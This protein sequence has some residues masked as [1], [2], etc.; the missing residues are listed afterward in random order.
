RTQYGLDD[1]SAGETAP[2]LA[3]F[4]IEP[5]RAAVL[6]V[7]KRALAI[8]PALRVMASPWSAPAWMKTTGSLIKGTLRPEAYPAFAEYLRRYIQGYEAEGVPIFA[9]TVQNEPHFE[10]ENYPG[11]R[12]TPAQRAELLAHPI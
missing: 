9:I 11:M 8:N 6:P 1:D 4:S 2:T 7:V 12:L 5:N 10:P 3:R